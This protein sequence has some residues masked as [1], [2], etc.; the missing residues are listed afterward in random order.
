MK[1]NWEIW[2]GCAAL[3]G[4][5][6]VWGL[7][8]AKRNFFE[9][10]NIHDFFEILA[11]IATVVAVVLAGMGL[12]A[13]KKQV[14][15][16]ADHELARRI[17]IAL[18]E[19]VEAINA[20]R[21]PMI[22]MYEITPER[23]EQEHPDPV[24]EEF[25]G[26]VRAYQRRL[27]RAEPVRAKLFSYSIEAEAVW[28]KLHREAIQSL[29]RMES[30]IAIYLRSYLI[31]HDPKNAPDMREAH[32]NLMA[33]KRDALR[34]PIGDEEDDFTRDMK[35]RFEKAKALLVEKFIR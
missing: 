3:F 31:S 26:E 15:A 14:R 33:G 13:W 6:V 30:E 34:G 19:Y 23:G 16:T 24:V 35:L 27:T 10:D 18:H 32:K 25:A 7:A 28:S 22:M 20:V 11:A 21:N 12:N 17:L 1:R 5:G 9:V 2:L 4:A 8:H 29:F